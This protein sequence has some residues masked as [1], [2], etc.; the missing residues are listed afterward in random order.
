MAYRRSSHPRRFEKIGVHPHALRHTFAT[1]LV[2]AGKEIGT[3]SKLMRHSSPS[4]TMVYAQYDQ[5]RL[6]EAV[7]CL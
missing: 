4:V 7:D 1:S 3:V 5:S 2:R 6:E